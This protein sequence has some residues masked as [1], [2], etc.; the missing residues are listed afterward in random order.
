MGRRPSHH[1]ISV[2]GYLI[3]NSVLS[4]ISLWNRGRRSSHHRISV[5]GHLIIKYW[6][7]VISS[8]N[9]GRRSSHHEIS[10]VGYLIGKCWSSVISSENGAFKGPQPGWSAKSLTDISWTV[11]NPEPRTDK[12]IK[13]WLC[14]AE[15]SIL[16]LWLWKLIDWGKRSR[17]SKSLIDQLR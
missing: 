13:L 12:K 7:S 17:W 9:F 5:V 6:P 2:V 11:H 8:L 15:L 10:V 16:K 14:N 4:V 1:E 3:M